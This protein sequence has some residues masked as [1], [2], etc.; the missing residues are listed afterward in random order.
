[1]AF[2]P[3]N[4]SCSVSDNVEKWCFTIANCFSY[5]AA[6]VQ[7]GQSEPYIMRSI[8]NNSTTSDW[9]VCTLAA[10]YE[11]QFSIVKDY[12]STFSATEQQKVFGANAVQFYK[13]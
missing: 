3:K 7:T 5:V 11:K 10:T 13:L 1:M 4:F 9:P 12:F 6:N 8:P 2:P